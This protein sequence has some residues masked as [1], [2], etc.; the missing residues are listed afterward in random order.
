[1]TPD[2][3]IEVFKAYHQ[4]F[5]QTRTIQWTLNSLIWTLL[6]LGIFFFANQDVHLK[7]VVF[8]FILLALLVLHGSIVVMIQKSLDG[9]KRFCD[10]IINQ[11]NISSKQKRNIEIDISSWSDNNISPVG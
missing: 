7:R 2:Q 1:M 5:N 4:R 6:A 11:L 3:A 10:R 9:N 8:Y